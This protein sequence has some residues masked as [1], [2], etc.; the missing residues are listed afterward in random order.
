[1]PRTTPP[2]QPLLPSFPTWL[3]QRGVSIG[4]PFSP[5]LPG[6]HQCF[7]LTSCFCLTFGLPPSIPLSSPQIFLSP[8]LFSI[9]IYLSLSLT[10]KADIQMWIISLFL[11]PVPG[12]TRY[13]V[14]NIAHTFNP[15]SFLHLFHEVSV[16][17]L[18]M[19]LYD[20]F[21]CLYI[22]ENEYVL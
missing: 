11:I 6:L 5:R 15:S 22:G 1:M 17:I 9:S 19:C 18:Y 12:W 16:Y 4:S 2:P 20:L 14:G 8:F 3:R 10:W 21:I 7:F 13:T